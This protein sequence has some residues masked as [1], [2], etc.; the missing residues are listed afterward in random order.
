M[1]LTKP[2]ARALYILK[3]YGPMTART[4]ARH[5]WPDSRG[6]DRLNFH[7]PNTMARAGCVIVGASM[8]LKG[9][10]YLSYLYGRGWTE[11]RHDKHHT[12]SRLG[13]TI[14]VSHLAALRAKG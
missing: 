4:F 5:M 13:S 2:A 9:G 10:Q 11:L 7:R 6:W 8:W 12:I 14:L 3:A 1:T